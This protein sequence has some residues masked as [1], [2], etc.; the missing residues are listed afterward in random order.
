ML[1]P[2]SEGLINGKTN[3]LM[4]PCKEIDRSVPYFEELDRT[5]YNDTTD[6]LTQTISLLH[7]QAVDYSDRNY[8]IK[9]LEK[10]PDGAITVEEAGK[11]KLKYKL[12]IN[13]N[14]Y[15]QYHRNNGITK[16]GT[17]NSDP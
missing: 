12:Q 13:D 4:Y 7:D 8:P 14:R 3:I 10:L 17:T 6:Y 11:K 5:N 9:H 2:Q 15:W 16:I 1:K